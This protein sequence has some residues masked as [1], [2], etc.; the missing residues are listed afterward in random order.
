MTRRGE[1]HYTR[2]DRIHEDHLQYYYGKDFA[3]LQLNP[4]QLKI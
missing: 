2:A 3:H 1:K 4:I